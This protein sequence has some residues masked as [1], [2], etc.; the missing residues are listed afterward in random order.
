MGQAQEGAVGHLPQLLGHGPVQLRP[1]VA[2]QVGPE[3]G[4]PVQITVALD[5]KQV[6]ALAPGDDQEFF[7]PEALHL[8]KGMPEVLS[9][10]AGQGF[11]VRR[12]F[13]PS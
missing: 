6:V 13:F 11:A 8:G 10:P 4:D 1:P 7:F 9:V 2:V 5:I 3:G 12:S